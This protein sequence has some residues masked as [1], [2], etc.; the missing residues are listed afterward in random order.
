MT[1]IAAL[2]I[3]AATRRWPL[4]RQTRIGQNGRPF[5]LLKLRTMRTAT[6]ESL[7]WEGGK[8]PDDPRVTAIGRVLRRTSIDELPQLLNVIAGQ[9]SLV[10][11]RPALPHEVARYEASWRRRLA[12]KPGLSGLWQVSGRSQVTPRHMVAMDRLYIAR[13]SLGLDCAVMLRTVVA[14]LSRRGAW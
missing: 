12:V 2:L 8:L 11:P 4:L 10:G 3:G 5:T 1:A 13:R 14:V 6:E 9:M 7:P